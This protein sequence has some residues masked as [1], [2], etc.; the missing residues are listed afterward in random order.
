MILEVFLFC[1]E[2]QNSVV[3]VFWKYQS[4]TH[5]FLSP[6]HFPH[7]VVWNSFL[8]WLY[9]LLYIEF[10][11]FCDLKTVDRSWVTYVLSQFLGDLTIGSSIFSLIQKPDSQ[12]HNILKSLHDLTMGTSIFDSLKLSLLFWNFSPLVWILSNLINEGVRAKLEP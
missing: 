11:N 10:S 9:G 3:L 5:F 7:L 12:K 1:P 8:N 6:K 4:L 2:F